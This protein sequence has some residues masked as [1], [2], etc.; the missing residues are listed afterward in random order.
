MAPTS[1]VRI[2]ESSKPLLLATTAWFADA[3]SDLDLTALKT[4]GGSAGSVTK[5]RGQGEPSFCF[6]AGET[7]I[8]TVTERPLPLLGLPRSPAF[9]GL[10]SAPVLR[11]LSPR[12]RLRL[13]QYLEQPAC[14]RIPIRSL[15]GSKPVD[16][17]IWLA[18]LT[19][20]EAAKPFP[21]SRCVMASVRA[22]D[23]LVDSST[24]S[25]RRSHVLPSGLQALLQGT[26]QRSSLMG[27]GGAVDE[28]AARRRM[29][30]AL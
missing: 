15:S 23:I 28:R 18:A 2:R 6:A 4:S 24:F 25:N 14:E 26:H 3:C 27:V 17:S 7:L 16:R 9:F 19:I 29:D 22:S 8:G 20:E 21:S 10:C 12:L 30:L 11:P 5:R 13:P 1:V